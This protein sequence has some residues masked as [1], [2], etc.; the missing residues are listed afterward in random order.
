MKITKKYFGGIFLWLIASIIIRNIHSS[1][2]V[3]YFNLENFTP[4]STH[5][6]FKLICEITATVFAILLA[7]ITRLANVPTFVI[8]MF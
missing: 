5:E 2:F 6:Y 3:D 1:C 7:V 8:S 4:E